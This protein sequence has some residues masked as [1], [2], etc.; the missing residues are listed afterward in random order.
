M[1]SSA[2]H[3]AED[4]DSLMEKMNVKIPFLNDESFVAFDESLKNENEVKVAFVSILYFSHLSKRFLAIM[5]IMI[6]F[7]QKQFVTSVVAPYAKAQ[8]AV[9]AILRKLVGKPVQMLYSAC[10]RKTKD[11][12]KKNFSATETYKIFESKKKTS[13]LIEI[14]LQLYIKIMSTYL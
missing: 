1:L 7:L 11:Y 8:D 4:L 14:R 2:G 12:Q 3:T 6:L 10:G 13:F 5:N 9:G